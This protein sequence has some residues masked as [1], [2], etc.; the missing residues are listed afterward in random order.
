MRNAVDVVDA[1]GHSGH[2]I[3]SWWAHKISVESLSWYYCLC[4]W[5]RSCCIQ[6][7]TESVKN[8]VSN[9]R[10]ALHSFLNLQGDREYSRAYEK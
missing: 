8:V 3:W 6:H 2:D 7:G 10:I 5:S 9:L 4:T 1:V